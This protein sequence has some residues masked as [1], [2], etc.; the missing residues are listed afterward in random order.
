MAKPTLREKPKATR[1]EKVVTKAYE[2]LQ[3]AQD[4]RAEKIAKNKGSAEGIDPLPGWS[5]FLAQADKQIPADEKS[6]ETAD[7]TAAKPKA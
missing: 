2:L 6:A 3:K 1:E 4:D 7:A 5:D